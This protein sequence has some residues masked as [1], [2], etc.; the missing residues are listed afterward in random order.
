MSDIVQF[1]PE[2]A[3]FP[4]VTLVSLPVAPSLPCLVCMIKGATNRY[5]PACRASQ[6]VEVGDIMRFPACEIHAQEFFGRHE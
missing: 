1:P 3:T 2:K 6:I 4:D 5:G